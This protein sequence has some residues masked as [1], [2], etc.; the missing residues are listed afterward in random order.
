MAIDRR[1][2]LTRPDLAGQ[3]LT[4]VLQAVAV[5]QTPLCQKP[6]GPLDDIL[7]RGEAFEVHHTA[8]GWAWGQA[9]VDHYV[10]YVRADALAPAATPSTHAITALCSHLYTQAYIKSP[11]VGQLFLGSPITVTGEAESFLETPT[12]F[13]H[14]QHVASP[15]TDFVCVAQQFEG[16]PY[17]WGGRSVAGIDCS[18]LVQM[19]LRAVGIQAP[20]DSDL[21]AHLGTT[22]ETPAR[23]DLVFWKGHVGI[24]VD[25]THILHA[26]AHHMSVQTE[27]L[28]N[29]RERIAP[30]YGTITAI[31]RL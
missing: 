1:F 22:V 21:Q 13:V 28:D 27:T 31:R 6:G 16:A 14:K 24:M 25:T 20:R 9:Q 4:P 15:Q 3:T 19:A 30:L 17:L 7:L 2:N 12:G 10:G 11:T 5:D 26:N 29:A 8:N 18:G 23:G